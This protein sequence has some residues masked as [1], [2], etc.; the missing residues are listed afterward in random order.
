MDQVTLVKNQV[1]A[2]NWYK[3]I[4][5][6]QGSGQTVVSWCKENDVNIKTYYYWLRK[7][8]QQEIEKRQLPVITEL[9]EKPVTFQRL[10]VQSPVPNTKAAVIIRMGSATVEVTEG[11]SQQ[12]IQA[13]LLALQSVC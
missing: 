12:T 9:P 4:E 10:E 13:V 1:R 6:C 7:F 2:Q 3:L 8:R 11:T 5:E